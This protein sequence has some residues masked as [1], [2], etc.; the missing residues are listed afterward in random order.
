MSFSNTIAFEQ[1]EDEA[2]LILALQKVSSTLARGDIDKT[3][4]MLTEL[5]RDYPDNLPVLSL[6]SKAYIYMEDFEK[7]L[8]REFGQ[9]V[10]LEQV[11]DILAQ[12]EAARRGLKVADDEL[13]AAIASWISVTFTR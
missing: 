10:L 9:P 3:L 1:S 8:L 11:R 7:R 6:M 13:N 5:D 2:R 4:I 12:Q